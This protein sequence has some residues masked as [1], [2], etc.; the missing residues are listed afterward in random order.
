MI[1][2]RDLLR[3]F[4]RLFR[5]AGLKLKMSEGF[6]PKPKVSFPSALALGFEGLDEVMELELSEPMPTDE[7][8]QTLKEFAPDGL[9]MLAVTRCGPQEKKAQVFKNCYEIRVPEAHLSLVAENLRQFL[10]SETHLITRDDKSEPLDARQ[11]IAD[12]CLQDDLLRFC[13]VATRQ[14]SVRPREI[15][16]LLGLGQLE[17]SGIY[18]TRSRVELQSNEVKTRKETEVS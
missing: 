8:H 3:L 1:S 7:L 9:G 17:A 5:R 10:E 13:I 11:D 16:E 6:H 12:A 18:L 2:H 15:L 4:E 14:R